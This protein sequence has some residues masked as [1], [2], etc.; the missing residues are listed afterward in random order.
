[1]VADLMTGSNP[2]LAPYAKSDGIH[3]RITAKADREEH[4]LEMISALEQSVR[5]RLGD[6]VYGLD[7]DTPYEAV[8]RLASALG[9]SFSVL[10]IGR[11]VAGALVPGFASANGFTGGLSVAALADAGT[12]LD[13]EAALPAIAR[14]FAERTRSDLVITVLVDLAALVSD[15]TIVRADVEVR[16]HSAAGEQVAAHAQSW[17]VPPGEVPRVAGLLAVNLL[18]RTLLKMQR[19]EGE[20]IAE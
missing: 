3:L 6:L 20:T 7:A 4:A 17:Q 18:R 2:T 1:M 13:M 10:E 16:V 15:E 19:R 14:A 8:G 12:C 9:V 5:E 11:G